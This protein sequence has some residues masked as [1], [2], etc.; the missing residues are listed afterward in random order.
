[1]HK[2]LISAL[3]LGLLLPS[4]AG[5]KRIDDYAYQAEI[6]PA[7]QALQR[8][9]LSI[10][11]LLALTRSDM[12]DIAVF[13]AQGMSLPHSLLQ[14][15]P[16]KT[17]AQVE[18]PF[19]EFDN[20]LRRQ[21]TTVTRREQLQQDGQI[22]QLETTEVVPNL[23]LRRDYLVELQQ[24]DRYIEKL[25]L[26]WRHAP[27]GQLLRLKVEIGNTLDRFRVLNASK[28]L[29]NLDNG[30]E[31]WRMIGPLPRGQK[32]LRLTPLEPIDE[33]RLERVVGHY[34]DSQPPQ[35]PRQRMATTPLEVQGKIFYQFEIPSRVAPES[36]QIIPADA[37]SVIRGDLHASRDQ[38][39]R[40][41][42]RIVRGFYQHNIEDAEVRT[43]QPIELGTVNYRQL[44]ISPSEPLGLPPQVELIYPAYELV[45]LGSGN[46]PYRLAWGNYESEPHSSDL[47]Q[48]MNINLADEKQRGESVS[49]GSIG[50][51]GGL[52]RINPAAVLPW[53][54]WLLWA[55]MAIAVLVTGAMAMKLFRDM[56]SADRG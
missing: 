4:L 55:L 37:H 31:A 8:L 1:M 16:R 49:L 32:Y 45:F 23:K 11:V 9:E 25:E 35:K 44:R 40:D 15:M 29:S 39:D 21:S 13:D 53:K 22:S 17:R 48:I 5:A 46:A 10:E 19:H 14:V 28:S 43:N 34:A 56:N 51:A 20:F 52:S 24:P 41:Q 26:Q 27:A 36:L 3:V 47:R 50:D 42:R 18:L 33:F 7:S 30:D 2:V 12:A 54:K 38:F 6:S